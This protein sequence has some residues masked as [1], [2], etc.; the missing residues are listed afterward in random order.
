MIVTV[1]RAGALVLLLCS[2]A[3]LASAQSSVHTT[4]QV[5][6][7]GKDVV[8]VPTPERAVERMLAM[9]QVGPNDFVIDLGSGD[10]RIVIMAAQRFGARGLGVELNPELVRL[11]A[12]RAK[13][14]GVADRATFVQ[15]DMFETDLRPAT[16]ITLY[17]LNELNLRLRPR[18]L[19]LAPGTRIVANAFDMGEWEADQLDDST[20]SLL[21]LWI[22]PA[23][24]AGNWRWSLDV[25]G[26]SRQLEMELNQQ[27]QRVSGVVSVEQQRL[28]LRNTRLNSDELRFTIIESQR[29][30]HSVRYDYAGRVHDERIEGEVVVNETN[31]RRRWVATRVSPGPADRKP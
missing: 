4:P 10:G 1:A 21:R 6:Q 20:I 30:D 15:R 12:E 31:N 26:R 17:L 23:R 19:Q 25:G 29:A 7:P 3:G 13:R 16:V 2:I 22:V 27:F 28:R 8:W 14:A 11:S 24:V 9:A 18:L 5:G